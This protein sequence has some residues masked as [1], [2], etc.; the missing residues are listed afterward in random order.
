MKQHLDKSRLRQAF[1]TAS[2]S[3]D[4]VAQLQR[5]VGLALLANRN[6]EAWQGKVLDI[7]CGTGFLTSELLAR[8]S[9][10]LIALDI[11]LPKLHTHG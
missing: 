10:E 1:S 8:S 2:P 7:G 6:I 5:Q 11:A 9:A 4:A 3:Y